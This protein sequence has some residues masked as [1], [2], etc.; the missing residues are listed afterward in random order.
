MF[1]SKSLSVLLLLAA[2]VVAGMLSLIGSVWRA[3]FL[4][5]FSWPFQNQVLATDTTSSSN[6]LDFDFPD[7]RPNSVVEVSKTIKGQNPLMILQYNKTTLQADI[8]N[9][10]ILTPD[11]SMELTTNASQ[12]SYATWCGIHP[13]EKKIG[14]LFSR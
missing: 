2:I 5:F 1:I 7:F 12:L 6:P 3:F 14:F 8:K 10:F 4:S 13:S 9:N 11:G